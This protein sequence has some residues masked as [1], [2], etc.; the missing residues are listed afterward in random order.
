MPDEPQPRLQDDQAGHTRW[1]QALTVARLLALNVQS[2]H[3]RHFRGVRLKAGAGPVRDAWLAAF[4]AMAGPD[5]PVVTINPDLAADRIVGGLDVTATLTAG[6]SIIDPGLLAQ[7][8]QGTLIING[9]D[10]LSRAKAALL[11]PAFDE[12]QVAVNIGHQQQNF[13]AAFCVIALDESDA[14][15]SSDIDTVAPTLAS[16]LPVTVDLHTI[17]WHDICESPLR[18]PDCAALPQVTWSHSDATRAINVSEEALVLI[19]E[20][21]RAVGTRALRV[22]LAAVEIAALLAAE[23]DRDAVNA[24]DVAEAAFI[25]F[26]LRLDAADATDAKPAEPEADAQT[27]A[28]PDNATNEPPSDADADNDTHS[29]KASLDFDALQ[30]LLVDAVKTGKVELPTVINRVNRSLASSTDGKSGDLAQGAKRGRPAGFSNRP[31]HQGARLNVIATL[32]AA[33]PW[34][35]LRRAT[36]L[37]QSRTQPIIRASDYRYIRFKKPAESTAI[38]AVDASGSTALDRLAEAKGAIEQLLAECYVRRDQVALVAFRGLRSEV[39]LEP[40]RSLVRAKRSLTGLPGGGPTPLAD[41]LRAGVELA[42]KAKRRGQSPLLVML[43][44]G[45]GNIALDGTADRHR[46]RDDAHKIARQAAALGIRTIFIDIAK[47]PRDQARE[48]ASA[49]HADYCALPRVDSS[50]VSAIVSSYLKQEG[51]R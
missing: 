31:P 38:F 19:A 16:R 29:D 17:A 46:A 20:M 43:T 48:L 6:R 24:D 37:D 18:A 25:T 47:R 41:G 1:M 3:M 9:A 49:M 8:D 26:G 34:Q 32:R 14:A 27:Q 35:K 7:A 51:T 30:E 33:A 5:R 36:A 13:P 11:S 50:A 23:D 15:D 40:T 22:E 4:R 21:S 39:L 28:E 12:Q 45:R 42:V 10:R 2:G 44:D